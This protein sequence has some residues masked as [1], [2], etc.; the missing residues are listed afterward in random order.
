[1]DLATRTSL[2]TTLSRFKRAIPRE[3][4]FGALRAQC[5]VE[6]IQLHRRNSSAE[7]WTDLRNIRRECR[8][9]PLRR[10]DSITAYTGTAVFL[11]GLKNGIFVTFAAAFCRTASIV[12]SIWRVVPSFANAVSTLASAMSFLRTGDHVVEVALPTC[13][14]PE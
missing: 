13:R 2:H 5:T 4:P 1:M 12:T 8:T 6:R 14:V 11:V 7:C 9:K 3:S 10:T